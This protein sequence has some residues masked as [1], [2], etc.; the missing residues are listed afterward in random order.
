MPKGQPDVIT[1]SRIFIVLMLVVGAWLWLD[2]LKSEPAGATSIYGAPCGRNCQF[3][4]CRADQCVPCGDED[5]PPIQPPGISGVLNCSGGAIV[6]GWCTTSLSLDLTAWDP[7]GSPVMIF[8]KVN[9]VDYSCPYGATTC[10]VPITAEGMGTA[11]YRVTSGTGQTSGEYTVNYQLDLTTPQVNGTLSGTPGLNNYYVTPVTVSATATDQASGIASLEYSVNG[12]G[13]TAYSSP[14]VLS[15]GI[16]SL[17]LRATDWA[18]HVSVTA[19]QTVQV[20]ATT[21]ILNASI[22]GTPGSNGW[23]VSQVTVS[24]SASDPGSSLASFEVN[25]D[26]GGYVPYSAPV[27]FTDG[28][29]T[30]QFKAVDIAGNLTETT[31]QTINVDTTTPTLTLDVA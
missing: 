30:I 29:H 18:G 6:N 19:P 26:G 17:T 2:V 5:P 27:I 15:D 1:P 21:P 14:F 28:L 11:S 22:S 10:S 31:T 23:Y 7:Y 16:Y 8:G 12:S 25:V 13:W 24:A 9:G 4:C 3:G 20:D